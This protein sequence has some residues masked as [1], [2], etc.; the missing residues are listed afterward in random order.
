MELPQGLS[1][2]SAGFTRAVVAVVCAGLGSFNALYCTQALMPALTADLGADPARASLA[3]SATTGVMAAAILP[4]SVLSERFGRGRV[5]ILSAIAAAVLGLVLPW[6]P[7]IWWLVAGRAVQGLLLA[8]VPATAMAWLSEEI[9]ADDLSW[10]MGLYVAGTTVGGLSGRLIPAM[11]LDVTSW[12][13]ALFA[14]SSVAALC[15]GVMTAVMPAQRR[16]RPKSLRWREESRALARHCR[17]RRLMGLFAVA[18]VLMGVFV[19]LYNYLGYHL[20]AEPFGL[21][22]TEVGSIFL[23]YLCGTVASARAGVSAARFGRQRVLLAGVG[24]CLAGMPAVLVDSLWM[25][26][27][28]TAVFT[29]GFFTVHSVASGWVGALAV[30]DRAEASGLYLTSYYLGSSVVGYLSG[31]VFHAYGWRALV[32]W[33]LVLIVA[34]GGL[35]LSEAVLLRPR[36]GSASVG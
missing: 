25:V 32:G 28:G 33:L 9:H 7:T 23:L 20:L 5:I 11:A 15:A 10:V 31:V 29:T 13:W 4:A 16:F 36:R 1:R 22:Q 27:L 17:D 6:A 14:T 26:L 19:S 34:A 18:F 8:G 21:S 2:G 30:R 24:L 12:S 35:A 3:V